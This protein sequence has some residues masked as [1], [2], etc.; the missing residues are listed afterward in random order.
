MTYKTLERFKEIVGDDPVFTLRMAAAPLFFCLPWNIKEH[1]M[2]TL[3]IAK[4]RDALFVLDETKYFGLA[5]DKFA[6]YYKGEVSLADLEE[7]YLLYEKH[8]RSLYDEVTDTNLTEATNASLQDYVRKVWNLYFEL[9]DTVYVETLDYDKIL[10]VIGEEQKEKLD[11]IWEQATQSTFVSFE[12]RYL[13]ALVELVSTHHADV[14]RKA[15]FIFTDYAWSKS[16]SEI[17]IALDETKS[18]LEE[19]RQEA[20]RM[21]SIAEKQKTAHAIWKETLDPELQRIVGYM[22]LV[23]RLRDVRKDPIAQMLAI[24]TEIAPLMLERVGI[25]RRAAPFVLIHEYMKGVE[26]LQGIRDDV[27][28]RENGCSYLAYPDESFSCEVEHCDFTDA[29]AQFEAWTKPE[30]HDS[31]ELRGQAAC[32]G[33][34]R[35]VVRVVSDPRDDRGFQ[36]GDI[37]V[38][39]MTR[40]EFVPIMK[41][42]GAVVTNE[43]GITCHAAI[44]SRE[45][46]IPCIIGTKIATQVL[47]DGDIVEVDADRGVVTIITRAT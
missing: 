47:K 37:L 34:V 32:R 18:S 31:Q 1:P 13:Q 30:L 28:A 7:V 23:M 20:K 19:K 43:G 45:L 26:Y 10:S 12:G 11:A 16:D 41:R 2:H 39:S 21:Y 29:M 15:K 44:V 38:T 6:Q 36:Q 4:G 40:P 42:A 25:D 33:L 3:C 22:Q 8:V 17:L 27:E 35:G 14:V 9:Q 5:T 46:G 24:M